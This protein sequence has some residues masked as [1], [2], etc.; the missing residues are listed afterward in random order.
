MSAASSIRFAVGFPAPWPALVSIRIN[1]GAWSAPLVDLL[2][3]AFLIVDGLGPSGFVAQFLERI[4]GRGVQQHL[5]RGR[6]GHRTANNLPGVL[7]RQ[8]T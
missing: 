1:A 6:I 7:I 3:A 5:L 2:L 8:P 4:I